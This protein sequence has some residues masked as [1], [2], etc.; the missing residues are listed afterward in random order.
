MIKCSENTVRI[1]KYI[2]SNRGI[3]KPQDQEEFHILVES[4][5]FKRYYSLNEHNCYCVEIEHM[6]NE[7][8]CIFELGVDECEFE[9]SYE[10]D[11][12]RCKKGCFD[13]CETNFH[14]VKIIN[15]VILPKGDLRIYNKVFSECGKPTCS[16]ATFEVQIKGD[17]FDAVK[18]LNPANDYMLCLKDLT[19]GKYEVTGLNNEDYEV[20]Y[21]VNG[22]VKD[23]GS[24]CIDSLDCNEVV[25]L[26]RMNNGMHTLHICN[27]VRRNGRL[28]KPGYH[29]SFEFTLKDNY[30]YKEYTLNCENRFCVCIEGN[31]EDCFELESRDMDHIEYEVNGEKVDFVKVCLCEDMDVRI[32]RNEDSC[33]KNEDHKSEED[34]IGCPK[35]NRLVVSNLIEENDC[36]YVPCKED[37]FAFRIQGLCD[38]VFELS[39]ENDF[40]Q[41]FENLESG[42]YCIY[43][44]G[45]CN[46]N[47]TFE[48]NGNMQEDGYFFIDRDSQVCINMIYHVC[49]SCCDTSLNTIT[50]VKRINGRCSDYEV[51]MPFNDAFYIAVEGN[52]GVEHYCLNEENNYCLDIF[53][54]N[55][56]YCIYE[57][58][59]ECD[60]EYRVDG[61]VC[62]N[63]AL[64]CVDDNDVEV[65]IINYMN[66]LNYIL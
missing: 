19:Y 61:N 6:P 49:S 20:R 39:C 9:V 60:V 50:L 35:G 63:E 27:W 8:Y 18:V 28:I 16:D 55:G 58:N 43:E 24:I 32:I 57:V 17:D 46:Q 33:I 3:N 65:M 15:T 52:D 54:E 11:G 2:E 12:H 42:Y 64:V 1:C 29:E 22:E 30:A 13:F 25:L 48:V 34:C 41:V 31:R 62:H 5:S 4:C 59:P 44:C 51:E 10:I 38:E 26:N 47:I 45:D 66:T 21:L 36:L 56:S 7:T 37:C 40:T 23:T 53:V 14:N